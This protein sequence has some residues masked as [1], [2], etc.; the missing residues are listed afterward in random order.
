MTDAEA[1]SLFVA[2]SISFSA[3]RQALV[4]STTFV[5]QP[6]GGVRITSHS[7]LPRT[8]FRRED[9]RRMLIRYQNG[10]LTLEELSIWGLVLHGLDAFEVDG[11]TELERETTWDVVAQLSAASINEKFNPERMSDMLGR[12]DTES[13]L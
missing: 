12:M 13:A 1:L 2:G 9:V 5:F 10:E 4:E 6:N 3:L 7:Q 8:M 11:G